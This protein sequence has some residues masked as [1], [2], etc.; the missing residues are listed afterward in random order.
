MSKVELLSNNTYQVVDENGTTLFQG[1]EEECKRY[2]L[3][4]FIKKITTTPE[5]LDVFKRLAN[6]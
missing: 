6:R 4:N 3:D 1:S 2:Q 5:L